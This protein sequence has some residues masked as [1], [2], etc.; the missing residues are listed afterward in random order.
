M[1]PVKLKMQAFASYAEA[2]EIN[3]EQLD[4]LFLIH[5][6][7]GAG[8]TAVLDAM[9][10][11][12]YGESSGGER[13]EMRCALP[14]AEDVPTEVEF[15][16]KVRGRLYKFTRSIIITP[17]SRKLEQRQD[18]FYFDEKTEQY[19]AFFENPKQTFVRQKAEELTGLTAEQFRQVIILPQGRFE[20]LLTSGSAEKE[21]I[22]STLF[23][24]EKYTKLSEKLS[25]KAE[26]CRKKLALEEA[27]LKA[28]LKAANAENAEQL[29]VEIG[30]IKNELNELS[31]KKKNA[32]GQLSEIRERL[33]AAELLAADFLSLLNLN[34]RINEL[35]LR[36]DVIDEMR[37]GL[38][39]HENASKA[40][41]EAM[42]AAAAEEAFAARSGQFIT[43]KDSALKSESRL[44]EILERGKLLAEK[45]KNHKARLEELAVLSR[46]APVYEK[47]S[48][49][50]SA[51]EK[52]GRERATVEKECVNEGN[53]LEKINTEAIELAA[54]R[55]KITTE[56]SRSL[57][58]LSA[59]KAALENG[60]EAEK[61]L[62][63]FM[64]ALDGIRKRVAVLKNEAEK[65][66]TG[67]SNAEK[68]YDRLY[69]E[70]ISN[71]AAELSSALK[72][73]MPCPVCGSTEHPCPA[74]LKGGTVTAED[75]K[76]ARSEFEK[77]A[78]ELSDKITEITAEESR[79]PAAEEYI[80]AEKRTVEECGYSFEEL[81]AVSEKFA[82]AERENAKL[83]QIDRQIELMNVRKA[84]LEAESRKNSERLSELKNAE[85]CA[86]AEI[87]ALRGQLDRRYPDAKSYNS[88]VA[89]LNAETAAFEKL[90][91]D[92]EQ[93]MKIAEKHKIEA[94]AAFEQAKAELSAA[95]NA[96]NA[97][98]KAFAEKLSKL[99][100]PS[101]E[102]YK[103]ALLNDD[104]AA[105]FSAETE[106]YTL[107]LHSVSEQARVLKKK[108]E[109]K[110]MPP[111]DE[112]RN[113]ASEAENLLAELSGREAVASEKLKRLE[114][115]AEDYAE[116]FEA[117]EKKRE[118][119]DKMTAFAKFM[120]GDKGISFTR[121]V[122]SIMLNLVAAEANRIL[123]DI[124]GGKF[125]LCVKTELSANSK[126]GL[127]LEVE[128][129][130][131]ETSVKYGVKNLSGGEKFLISLA[132]SLGLSSVARSRS[133][134]IEI[135]AM[136]IDEGFGSL[137][138]A[139]LREAIA[140]LC[141]LTS[142]RN[143]I[144]IISH[145]DE[146]K[147]VIPCGINIVK[148]KDGGSKVM[149]VV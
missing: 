135:E 98:E 68:A 41:P 144:G 99:G 15:V 126:Q 130:T 81:Q 28:M 25:E 101:A 104:I 102:A 35:E 4:S 19:R 34:E 92:F 128:N 94:Y 83:P 49:A 46:L 127:D 129:L 52:I 112:I 75:V 148:D 77:A 71:T 89:K 54:L 91:A 116:K 111:V 67:K 118:Q 95:E 106:K 119:C 32:A 133:G 24:A 23:G 36:R 61:R 60:S 72:E 73:G 132:L 149:S 93:T 56:Y 114:R 7:T 47:I 109:G 143:T 62:R 20:R 21:T 117:G 97:A 139:S 76:K 48:A 6:E 3:F 124:H 79:I 8:K 110:E 10:Y 84:E 131:A 90:K 43:A 55:E 22:L 145:V 87:S 13:T 113:S 66:S 108:L 136:F 134:G 33:T 11:A 137:D 18:C 142:R 82:A 12:L 5:G 44:S 2:A 26:A 86:L 17:R 64:S 70:Y 123:A 74:A 103:N 147:N 37:R 9:M 14:R 80:A 29:S 140:I 39:R 27:D 125:R 50:E 30:Q 122:L 40:K 53:A 65:L 63:K 1:L 138:P 78:S 59:R 105:R 51:A 57:P 121:Y 85:A 45:E 141:G 58:A 38:S 42:A 69:S 31:P 16:F 96:K 115:L 146:L 100:I 120:H 107:E 88:G